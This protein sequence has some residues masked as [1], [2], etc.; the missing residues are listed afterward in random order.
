[1]AKKIDFIDLK[2][3]IGKV[4]YWERMFFLNKSMGTASIFKKGH[5]VI[6]EAGLNEY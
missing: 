5:A 1:M 4:L 6:R 3:I 2:A